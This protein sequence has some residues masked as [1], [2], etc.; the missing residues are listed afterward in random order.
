M[1]REISIGALV[2]EMPAGSISSVTGSITCKAVGLEMIELELE[3]MTMLT[4][5]SQCG[6]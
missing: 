4:N 3:M 1:G 5:A 6:F 2:V